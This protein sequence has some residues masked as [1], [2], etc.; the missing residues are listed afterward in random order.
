MLRVSGKAPSMSFFPRLF[1]L[2]LP[3]ILL[4]LFA[5]FEG[6]ELGLRVGVQVVQ[7][8]TCSQWGAHSDGGLFQD[9]DVLIGGLFSIHYKPPP[10]AHNFTHRPNY[11]SCTG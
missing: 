10:T 6:L 2:W 9:G 5:G 1:N 8:L 3:S 4:L 7:A 11:K